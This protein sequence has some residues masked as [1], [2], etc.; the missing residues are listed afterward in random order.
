[1]A[2]I[3]GVNVTVQRRGGSSPS[4]TDTAKT[5]RARAYPLQSPGVAR[6][7]SFDALVTGASTHERRRRLI[8][9]Y[10]REAQLVELDGA[11]FTNPRG[12]TVLAAP[13]GERD[14]IPAGGAYSALGG[15]FFSL[16]PP[17]Q[18]RGRVDV[19]V[20]TIDN[21]WSRAG[22]T[23][24]LLPENSEN[25]SDAFQTGVV[26]DTPTTHAFTSNWG[27]QD[28]SFT[29]GEVARGKVL[30]DVRAGFYGN[31]VEVQSPSGTNRSY[32]GAGSG[33]DVCEVH[34]R[35]GKVVLNPDTGE[36]DWHHSGNTIGASVTGFDQW[37]VRRWT[38]WLV[39]VQLPDEVVVEVWAH[40]LARFRGLGSKLGFD[41]SYDDISASSHVH[42]LQDGGTGQDWYVSSTED[43]TLQ[44]GQLDADIGDPGLV[45]VFHTT[46][47]D[48]DTLADANMKELRQSLR[49]EA[50]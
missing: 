49:L 42:E 10:W 48:Q 14:Q 16:G 24:V 3:N 4:I 39:E 35:R 38:P 31:M 30:F 40:G 5:P 33:S 27:D 23:R 11:G 21:N 28:A 47:G 29:G 36:V 7:A 37:R 22:V 12:Q 2:T 8:A 44:G 1:M 46:D 19:Q 43:W 32:M 34:H 45:Y 18:Y 9:E 26:V 20:K 41:T 13:M 25:P 50:I 6:Q 17:G 15:S